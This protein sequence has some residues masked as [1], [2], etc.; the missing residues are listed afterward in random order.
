MDVT[1]TYKFIGFGPGSEYR[2]RQDIESHVDSDF[3]EA[4]TTTSPCIKGSYLDN[5]T[6]FSTIE[7][8]KAPQV[9]TTSEKRQAFEAEVLNKMRNINN[10]QEGRNRLES[11]ITSL[12]NHQNQQ[13]L[14]NACDM[15]LQ[16]INLFM[17]QLVEEFF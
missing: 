5:G 14:L 11:V 2:G 9:S 13:Y 6:Y 1:K 8:E 15:N 17:T 12:M 16:A 3:S 10:T 7:H 4:E